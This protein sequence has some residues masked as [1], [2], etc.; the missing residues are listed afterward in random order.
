MRRRLL[1]P[2]EAVSDLV[3]LKGLMGF[4]RIREGGRK[5]RELTGL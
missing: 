5:E 4:G 2:L 1:R 3:P